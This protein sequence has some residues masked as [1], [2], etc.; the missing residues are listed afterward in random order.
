MRDT[1]QSVMDPRRNPL[2]QLPPVQRFQVM[3]FL[4]MMW[5]AIFSASFG[6]W[7]WYGELIAAHVVIVFLIT[8]GSLATRGVF[9]AANRIKSHRD[10]PSADGTARYDDIWGG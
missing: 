4:S 9:R 3:V 1:Y 7:V 8:L 2:N 5:T 6:L 10:H